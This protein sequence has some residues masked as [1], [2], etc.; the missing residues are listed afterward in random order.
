MRCAI[1]LSDLGAGGTQR[2]ALG[3]A[4]HL[5]GRGHEVDILT[6]DDPDA[7]SLFP[8]PAGAR[9]VGLGLRADSRGLLEAFIANRARVAALRL[10]LVRAGT[11][12]VISFLTTTNILTLLAARPLGL[13]VT[14][15]E[16]SS[17]GH[18]PLPLPW[19]L[20]RWLTY[21]WAR[22]IVVHSRGAGTFFRGRLA[23]RVRVIPNPVAPC[24]TATDGGPDGGGSRTRRKPVV[25]AMGRLSPEKGFD[26]L[27]AAFA[28]VAPQHPEWSLRILGDGPLR[29]ALLDQAAASGLADRIALPGFSAQP[30]EAFAAA[31]LF[32]SAARVE[33]FGIALCEAMAC[34][35]PAVA[36]DAPS[37][38]RDIVRPGVDG[39][40]VP[41]DDVRALAAALSALMADPDRRATYGARAREV[42]ERFSPARVWA[43]WDALIDQ[44]SPVDP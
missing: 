1:C 26:L 30:A 20:L 12:R 33:G 37:G 36:T 34:G 13:P 39:E 38:P 3:L 6:L 23:G 16:E 9:V 44:G 2:L 25:V 15:A 28:R 24:R 10:A 22:Y 43:D 27:I 21:G 42:T 35:L 5:L 41:V 4:E 29:L 31:S 18:E 11:E 19:A 40:L 32:C 17:P 14:V 7:G 8:L